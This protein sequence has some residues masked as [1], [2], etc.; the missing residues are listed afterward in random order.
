MVPQFYVTSDSVITHSK[1]G[2]QKS[3]VCMGVL[4]AH[5]NLLRTGGVLMS[6]VVK[7][8]E[9]LLCLYWLSNPSL[10]ITSFTLRVWGSM[11]KVSWERLQDGS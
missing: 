5:G 8:Y 10:C 11:R 6:T 3:H 9:S 1:R 7:G 4:R 2:C